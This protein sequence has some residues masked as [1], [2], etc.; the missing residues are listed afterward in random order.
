[1]LYAVTNVKRATLEIM[2]EGNLQGLSRPRTMH[3]SN[4]VLL[5]VSLLFRFLKRPVTEYRYLG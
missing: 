1:M 3:I 5:V 4:A 2:L